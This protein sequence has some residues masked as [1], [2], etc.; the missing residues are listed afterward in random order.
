MRACV[1]ECA[2][3]NPNALSLEEGLRSLGTGVTG[4]PP[5]L[6]P[7]I[8]YNYTIISFFES[9]Y[10]LSTHDLVGTSE[11]VQLKKVFSIQGW[12]S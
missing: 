11:M 6:K 9:L 5:S 1:W 7:E 4:E 10:G 3:V 12:Q 2:D 8:F